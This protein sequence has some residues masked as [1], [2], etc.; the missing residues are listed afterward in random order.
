VAALVVLVVWGV[1]AN[2]PQRKP[3]VEQADTKAI[4]TYMASKEFKNLS[5][6]DR[7][8]FMERVQALPDDKRRELFRPEGVDEKTRTALRENMRET[9][10]GRMLEEAKSFFKLGADEQVAEL[11][12]RIDDMEAR[13]AEF[14]SRRAA[15][16]AN[17][18]GRGGPGRGPRGPVDPDKVQ[19]RM[20]ERIESR[21]A[22]ERAI[23]SEY[24]K[25]LHERMQQRG[26]TGGPGRGPGMGRG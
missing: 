20:Q 8:D 26:I 3:V 24:F 19:A 23:M 12:K 10:E 1:I 16:D 14:A 11:D 18:P 9:M 6:A 5:E 13:R 2:R 4:V 15:G 21:P 7:E 22:E 25:R 17:S